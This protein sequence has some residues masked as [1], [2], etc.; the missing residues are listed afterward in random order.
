MTP[1]VGPPTSRA[2]P[3]TASRE[4]DPLRATHR[5]RGGENEHPDESLAAAAFS[6]GTARTKTRGRGGRGGGGAA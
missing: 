6:H 5:N 3:A 2:L 4:V 1:I